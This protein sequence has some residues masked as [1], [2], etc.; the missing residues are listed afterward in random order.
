MDTPSRPALPDNRVLVVAANLRDLGGLPTSDGRTVRTGRLFRSGYLC[1]L[2]GPPLATL[3]SLGL[4]TIVDLRRPDE[5]RQ[6]PHPDLNSTEVVHVSVSTDDNEFAVLAN[7]M[8]T[9]PEA[10][11]GPDLIADYFRNSVRTRL[12]RYRRVFALATDPDRHPLLFNCTAGKDRT[13]FVGGILLR[14][15]GVAEEHAIAD[16]LLSNEVRRPWLQ[17]REDNHRRLIADRLGIEP[18]H[19]PDEH[20]VNSRAMLWCNADYLTAAFSTVEEDWGTWESFRR[21]GLDI[22]DARFDA[23]HAAMLA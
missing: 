7:R 3:E 18:D 6:R 16:Y 9:E 8:A 23:F 12:D 22:D 21:N 20:L 17:E 4:R 15:L 1:D 10:I 14:L 5:A 2:D 11:P 19:V 13:G